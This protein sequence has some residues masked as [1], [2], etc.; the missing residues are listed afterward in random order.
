GTEYHLGDMP[1]IHVGKTGK[2][3]IENFI[4][5]LILSPNTPLPGTLIIHAGG[6]DY[7]SQ[8]SGAAGK[9]IACGVIE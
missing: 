1:N 5:G 6:D 8:P 3:K 7:I 4:H 9:R 2:L